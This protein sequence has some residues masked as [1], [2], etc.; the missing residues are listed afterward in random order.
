LPALAALIGIDIG[1][2][3]AKGVLVTEDGRV[4]GSA[5]AEYPVSM[6]RA[7]WAEQ[8]PEDWVAATITVIRQLLEQAAAAGGHDGAAAVAGLALSGQ[9]HGL[10]CLDARNEILRPAML[11][12]DT[13]TTGECREIEQALGGTAGVVRHSY[14]AA[15]EGF[16]LPK[17]LW[18]RKHEPDVYSRTR[19]I[20]L[21]KDYVRFR[22]TG[23]LGMDLSDA[24]GTL[25]LD[26]GR[27]EWSEAIASALEVDPAILPPLGQS[28]AIAGYLTPAM[29]QATG[30]PATLPVAFGGADNACAAVGTGVISEGLTAVSI[31]T[32]GTVIAPVSRPVHDP[33]GRTHTF[34]HAVPQLWY[35]MGVMQAA[36]LSLKWFKDTL[37]AAD[38]RADFAARNIYDVLSVEAGN[39]PAG[40]EGL[41]WLPYLNGERTPHMDPT[42]RGVLFGITPRHTR[43]HIVRA[44]MEGVAFGL[45][46]SLLLVQELGIPIQEIR[47]TGG[48]ARSSVWKQILADVFQMPI[49]TVSSEE[50]PALGAAIIAGVATG[51]YP[52]FATACSRAIQVTAAVRPDLSM[53]KV[54]E[55]AH[56]R[57]TRLYQ[58][59]AGEFAAGAT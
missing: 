38:S 44:I 41:L 27:Q 24:A 39:V 23:R 12:C 59:L 29:A 20:L 7:G 28:S 31:G 40:C 19:T 1:T 32:S 25:L 58:A 47:L 33:Q 16:T 45:K 50:G 15:L 17:L 49:S 35:V 30:L 21:P 11:W 3:G 13:R 8:D 51:V 55:N 56:G 26:V 57:Y 42:A 14:N 22:L 6:P 52:D 48:G 34:I 54:Y 2:S 36:G 9:M 18:V 10:V 53:A 37:C 4:L 46:D 43:G 5:F